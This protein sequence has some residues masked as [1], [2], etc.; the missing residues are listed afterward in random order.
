M[1]EDIESMIHQ[2]EKLGARVTWVEERVS[3]YTGPKG[4]S[5]LGGGENSVAFKELE[6]NF[7]KLKRD[8]D[9]NKENN[10]LMF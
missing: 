4:K 2:K 9:E 10:T 8:Y 3:G 6:D 1:D 7:W 5:A